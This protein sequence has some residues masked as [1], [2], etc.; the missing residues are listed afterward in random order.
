M[1]DSRTR[2]NKFGAPE[3]SESSLCCESESSDTE[4]GEPVSDA[5]GELEGTEVVDVVLEGVEFGPVGA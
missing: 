5:E 1:L 3:E 2:K 4:T